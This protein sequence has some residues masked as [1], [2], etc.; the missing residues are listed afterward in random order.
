MS[1]ENDTSYTVPT[2]PSQWRELTTDELLVLYRKVAAANRHPHSASIDVELTGRLIEALDGF[3]RS[4]DRSSK[5]LEWLTLV[6]VILTVVIVALT[7]VLVF[8]S[9]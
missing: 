1:D 2:K 6:L 8:S 4:A 9:E 5:R 7:V 3:R